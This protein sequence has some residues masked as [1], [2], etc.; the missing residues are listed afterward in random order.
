MID[1]LAGRLTDYE[2]APSRARC[3]AHILN[4]VVKSVMHQFDIR[5]KKG[6]E[7][8][9]EELR[10]LAG[11]IEEEERLTQ[12]QFEATLDPDDD[13]TLEDNNKGWVDGRE[14]MEE[15]ELEEL[16]ESVRPICFLLTK[17][18]GE[19]A[20]AVQFYLTISHASDSQTCV[21]NQKFV[22]HRP[23]SVVL[24]RRKPVA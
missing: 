17:V 6:N 20:S 3:F 5:K 19:H 15:E 9:D 13:E 10:E 1:Q 11:D 14:D 24:H 23:S 8:H 12:A 2:G 21:C 7:T 22:H 4:L 18:G 16:E